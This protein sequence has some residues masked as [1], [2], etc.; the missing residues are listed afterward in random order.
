[1]PLAESIACKMVGVM[2]KTKLK[3]FCLKCYKDK[4]IAHNIS[5][6]AP[7]V[8]MRDERFMP[9]IGIQSCWL[10]GSMEMWL[11][12]VME[13]SKLFVVSF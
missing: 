12:W 7:K 5:I 13:V 9:Y 2:E 8:R 10:L 4:L 11:S 1:M 6:N 3:Y